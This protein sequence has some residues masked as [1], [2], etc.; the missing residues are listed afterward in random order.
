MDDSTTTNGPAVDTGADNAQ[1]AVTTEPSAENQ[2]TEPT[3]AESEQ[4]SQQAAPADDNLSWL[5]NKGIDPQSPEALAK[6]AEMYRNAE[7]QMHQNAQKAS[8]LEQSITEASQQADV[9]NQEPTP[10]WV[11]RLNQLELKDKVNTFFSQD[12]IDAEMRPKMAEYAANNPNVSYL[13]EN[14]IMSMNDLY[15]MVRGSDPGLLSSAK[16]EGGRE[17]LQKVADK[18]QAKA[19]TGAA[20]SSQMANS[21]VTRENFN[22]WYSS[23]TP[24]QRQDPA[25]QAIANSV[26][27]GN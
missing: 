13:V 7:K 3:H 21:T 4:D 6:V 26:L 18:Q 17:A 12:G 22:S 5:S 16:Q 8:T 11:A 14:G 15:N 23:L 10:E 19:V 2:P 20:T 9:V 27:G 25:N 24:Q 1:P